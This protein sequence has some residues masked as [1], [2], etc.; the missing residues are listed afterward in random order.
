[1]GQNFASLAYGNCRNLP[2]VLNVFSCEESIL[3]K[4]PAL[5]IEKFPSLV[6]SRNAMLQH[7]IMLSLLYYLPNGCLQEVK[8]N[9]KF[10]TF[11]SKKRSQLLTR[12]GRLQ[13][14]PNIE[15]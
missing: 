5:L 1:L 12:G 15:I 4:N 14:V 2:H 10:Q 13:E 9:R 3:R 11:S 7:L 6:L 8:N